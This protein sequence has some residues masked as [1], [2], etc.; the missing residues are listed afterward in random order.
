MLRKGFFYCKNTLKNYNIVNK[1][2]PKSNF[3]WSADGLK[4]VLKSEI[5]HE[6]Q[7]YSPV[8]PKEL[9]TFYENTKFNFVEKENSLNMELRKSHGNY[10]VVV[11]FQARPPMPQEEQQ[12]E[13]Q[14]KCKI[15]Y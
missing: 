6:S 13:G 10:E 9:Q 15:N 14:E 4:K 12:Q 7:N 3:A 11:N 2:A 5:D 1:F 8:D